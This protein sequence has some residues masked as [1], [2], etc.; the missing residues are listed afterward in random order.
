MSEENKI[1]TLM[2]ELWQAEAE[3]KKLRKC[4]T[5]VAAQLRVI[6][7]CLDTSTD[8]EILEFPK[9]H[10]FTSEHRSE[11]YLR[12]SSFSGSGHNFPIPQN[13]EKLMR[14]IHKLENQI[15]NDQKRVQDFRDKSLGID[16][17]VQIDI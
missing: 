17:S 7:D 6:A 5:E 9:E 11:A 12:G 15:Q 4:G 16:P 10:T 3:L 14:R 2:I 8:D 13:V 1:G